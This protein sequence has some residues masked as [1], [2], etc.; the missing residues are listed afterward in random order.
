MDEIVPIV[1]GGLVRP[2]SMDEIREQIRLLA[3][4]GLPATAAERYEVVLR[5]ETKVLRKR[6]RPVRFLIDTPK[7]GVVPADTSLPSETFFRRSA[8]PR[9]GDENRAT[10]VS[11][12]ELKEAFYAG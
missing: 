4:F 1:E 3:E 12:V 11:T 6:D 10:A 8:R 7:H 9:F 5:G 2:G